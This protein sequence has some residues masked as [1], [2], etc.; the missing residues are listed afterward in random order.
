LK[1][2]ELEGKY[3]I[4]VP[5]YFTVERVDRAAT[6]VP[7]YFFNAPKPQYTTIQVFVLPRA[8]IIPIDKE[9]GRF[10]LPFECDG[11]L[12]PLTAYFE[13][14]GNRDVYYGS[15]LSKFAG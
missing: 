13:I 4:Q 15:L 3:T 14:S 12:P 11:G 2:V 7:M 1:S 5:D 6:A 8:G 9:T 10:Q